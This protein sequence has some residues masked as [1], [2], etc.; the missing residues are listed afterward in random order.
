VILGGVERAEGAVPLAVEQADA[1]AVEDVE[2]L[3][4][5]ARA[6]T[7]GRRRGWGRLRRDRRQ[8]RAAEELHRPVCPD[9]SRRCEADLRPERKVEVLG[10]VFQARWDRLPR[11][12]SS[13]RRCGGGSAKAAVCRRATR[14]GGAAEAAGERATWRG[15]GWIAMWGRQMA[16]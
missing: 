13:R 11:F 2:D 3:R 8:R 12:S 15:R 1:V 4:A 7:R 9:L 16:G 14:W 5:G 6:R 10:C